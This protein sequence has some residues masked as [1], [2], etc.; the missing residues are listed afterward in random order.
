[1]VCITAPLTLYMHMRWGHHHFPVTSWGPACQ[2]TS[3]GFWTPMQMWEAKPLARLLSRPEGVQL[4]SPAKISTGLHQLWLWPQSKT[5]PQLIHGSHQVPLWN[6]NN[7]EKLLD[8]SSDQCCFDQ[9]YLKNTSVLFCLFPTL[10]FA[11]W[12]FWGETAQSSS[13]L[14]KYFSCPASDQSHW[15][16]VFTCLFYT[17]INIL[18]DTTAET[19]V[20]SKAV[21]YSSKNRDRLEDPLTKKIVASISELGCKLVMATP[22]RAVRQPRLKLA[23]TYNF[24]F[25]ENSNIKKTM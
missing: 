16:L 13:S 22:W 23:I 20:L 8:L 7:T 10:S 21:F 3:V 15:R 1:M 17:K 2:N 6:N 5:N 24:C 18:S 19:E 14:A 12:D 11:V 25:L 4:C 9:H